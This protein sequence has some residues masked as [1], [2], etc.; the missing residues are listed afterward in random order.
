MILN[1]NPYK[2]EM[3]QKN[4]CDFKELAQISKQKMKVGKTWLLI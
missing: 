1:K 2:Y 3:L 4:T